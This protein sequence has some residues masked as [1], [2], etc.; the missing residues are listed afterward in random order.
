MP[1]PHIPLCFNLCMCGNEHWCASGVGATPC[2]T[3]LLEVRCDSFKVYIKVCTNNITFVAGIRLRPLGNAAY[4][5]CPLL[6]CQGS[7]WLNRK[8]IW[9]VFRRSWVRIPDFFLDWLL[10]QQRTSMWRTLLHGN[11][12]LNFRLS[13]I[14]LYYS[15]AISWSYNHPFYRTEWCYS[16]RQSKH[17]GPPQS[18]WAPTGSWG[19]P[20]PTGQGKTV[21]YILMVLRASLYSC[22]QHLLYFTNTLI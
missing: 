6:L 1:H 2:N 12:N 20:W 3:Q 17:R 19:K 11:T 18:S 7:E 10:S 13:V 14:K 9:Q 22:Y 21:M 16:T 8:S 5:A 15:I 4:V